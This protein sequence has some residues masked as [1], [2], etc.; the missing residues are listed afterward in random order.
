MERGEGWKGG[1]LEDEKAPAGR[2]VYSKRGIT[3]CKA[4]EVRQVEEW[5]GG[6]LSESPITRINGFHG[7]KAS[8]GWR[9]RKKGRRRENGDSVG[10]NDR[11]SP[12]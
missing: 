11:Y 7:L 3:T 6:R 9:A 10:N 1:R 5:K 12:R 2:Q 8:D 4:P